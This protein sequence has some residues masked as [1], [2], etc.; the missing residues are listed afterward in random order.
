[1]PSDQ[2]RAQLQTSLGDGYTL[3]R[4]VGGGGM[5]RVFVAR[6]L[7][8]GR[9]VVVKV[10][11]PDMAADVSV[12]RFRREIQLGAQLQHPHIVPVL[13]HGASD[14]LLYYTMPLIEG[15]SLR[16]RLTSGAPFSSAEAVRLWREIVDALAYAHSRGVVHRDI[17]PE[18]ILLSN[19]HAQVTDFGI[20][21]AV[22]AATDA[23][24]MTATGLALGTPAYMAP[25]QAAGEQA[26]D[27]RADLYAAGLVMYEMLAGAPAFSARSARELIVAQLTQP[28]PPLVP[29][30][31]SC[32][33]EVIALVMRCIEKDPANR[34]A[35]AHEV[36]ATL[37][38]VS[39][40]RAGTAAPPA[41]RRRMLI[42]A[43]SVV[44]LVGVAG[45][46]AAGARHFMHAAPGA[47]ADDSLRIK[48]M[49]ADTKFDGGDSTLANNFAE[50]VISDLA[51]D[52]WMMA[53]SPEDVRQWASL[54]GLPPKSLT[55][56]TLVFL[57]KRG[58]VSAYVT[59]GISRAGTGYLLTA[60]PTGARNDNQLPAVT[61]AATGAAGIPAA[62]HKVATQLHDELLARR[63]ELPFS[64]M[65]FTIAPV[66]PRAV[67]HL[68]AGI[69]ASQRNDWTAAA[70][71][72]QAA[73]NEDS[74]FGMAWGALASVLGN[75]GLTGA[76]L[77]TAVSHAYRLR[78]TYRSRATQL[79][80][81]GDYWLMVGQ[82]DRAVA[83]Y[84]SVVALLPNPERAGINNEA[85]A[86]ADLR[87]YDDAIETYRKLLDTT[88][89]LAGDLRHTRLTRQNIVYPLLAT[90]KVDEARAQAAELHRGHRSDGY[91]EAADIM[92]FGGTRA[93]AALDSLC[94][95]MLLDTT[96][97]TQLEALQ[98]LAASLSAQGRLAASDSAVQRRA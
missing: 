86:F 42:G 98:F 62:M 26:L 63:A 93:R 28:A 49:I 46:L 15:E 37:D 74:T 67:E 13:A 76:R 11:P 57:A 9:P 23:H 88:Y 81:A 89:H 82:S 7:A 19:G 14:S 39:T 83:S 72:F 4:E 50:T 40:P 25:E 94:R 21:R 29:R 45:A 17:K 59:L 24:R 22:E 97:S 38:A 70:R 34:P 30:D 73:I 5:S 31:A 36:I 69:A 52:P 66:A 60:A 85:L 64:V 51:K 10:L 3:E 61:V 84:D 95:G 8:L 16:Q 71:E 56:D 58:R 47:P 12:D 35:T 2:L 48:V 68:Q 20:A 75:E 79:G 78:L 18:N 32:P 54:E 77:M 65:L 33:P 96:R 1:M 41:R 6:E 87:R 55:R 44:L 43:T 92:M 27:H 91:S 90:G 80:M 53:L